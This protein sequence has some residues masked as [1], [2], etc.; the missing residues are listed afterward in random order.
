MTPQ[1][2][3]QLKSEAAMA[4]LTASVA[5]MAIGFSQADLI[6]EDAY[7]ASGIA[8]DELDRIFTDLDSAH[9]AAEKFKMRY[10]ALHERVSRATP[11]VQ[12]KV[13]T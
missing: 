3:L 8:K 11:E 5:S 9:A 4:H 1:K 2:Q 6:R 10:K 7:N 13:G 12:T